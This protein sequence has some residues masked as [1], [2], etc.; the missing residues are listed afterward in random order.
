M[1]PAPQKRGS[2]IFKKHISNCLVPQGG[3]MFHQQCCETLQITM[4]TIMNS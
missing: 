4:L 2:L 3:I 1:L